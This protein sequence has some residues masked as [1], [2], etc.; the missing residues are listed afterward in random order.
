MF[1]RGDYYTVHARDAEFVARHVFQT[2]TVI[3][4]FGNKSTLKSGNGDEMDRAYVTLT[5]QV[6]ENLVRDLLMH[7]HY[8]V[9]IYSSSGSK[10]AGGWKLVRRGSPGN[11]KD[12]E[13]WLFDDSDMTSA[14]VVACVKVQNL[15][16]GLA[17]GDATHRRLGWVEF[18]DNALL[19][20]LESTIIQ[21]GV[22]ECLVHQFSSLETDMEKLVQLLQRCNIVVTE[23]KKSQFDDASLD[24]DLELLCCQKNAMTLTDASSARQTLACLMEYLDLTADTASHGQFELKQVAMKKYMRLDASAVQA[25]HMMPSGQD[26]SQ[27]HASL[28]GLLNHC[29]TA[30]GSRLLAT[31]LKQP[32]M[33]VAEIEKRQNLVQC[34]FDSAEL[35]QQFQEEHLKRV[36]DL[37]KLSKKFQ[38]SKAGIRDIVRFYDAVVQ[39]PLMTES[40][41]AFYD[42]FA[43]SEEAQVLKKEFLGP[44]EA[45][46]TQVEKFREMVEATV[47]LEATKNHLYRIRADYHENLVELRDEMDVLQQR[48]GNECERVASDL[49]LE[50]EKKLKLEKTSQFGYCMRIARA[51]SRFIAGNKTYVELSVQK[52]GIFFTTER[53]RGLSDQVTELMNSYE[54]KQADVVKEIVGITV[55]YAPVMEAMSEVFGMLDVIVAFAHV[56]INAPV[57]YARPKVHEKG[58]GDLVLRDARH[59]C[60]ELQDDVCFIAND[61]EMRRGTSQFNIITG[62]N[63]GG[64]STF[65]RQIGVIALLAQVGCF[66]PCSEAELP[67]FDAILAR[68]GAGDMQL[69]GVSTFMAEMLET[70]SILRTASPNS[71]VIVDE[72]GRGTSTYDGFGLAWAIS[73]DLAT[74]VGCFT[75]FATHFHELT[76]LSEQVSGV[77]NLHVE[78]VLGDEGIVLLYKVKPGAENQSFGIH[79]AEM[80][81]FPA[82]T[83]KMARRKVEELENLVM[84][85]R[86]AQKL[87]VST[88]GYAQEEVDNGL[89][90]V[91]V[92]LEA[93]DRLDADA[94]DDETLRSAFEPLISKFTDATQNNSFLK[95]EVIPLADR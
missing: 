65:I 23:V 43:H 73:H 9:E 1:D 42:T 19:S 52:S 8:R 94:M 91:S 46:A 35:R 75:L 62:P 10:A 11:L 63:M 53:M 70:A 60:L 27:R 22:K 39:L 56:A 81:K 34:F 12:F 21:L 51:D 2:T 26:G 79:C 58:Q 7:Q 13:D 3:K 4:Y 33:Q 29:S 84:N 89:G 86:D 50:L 80:A 5:Q 64:K 61:V 30:P 74:R 55:T 59:P 71:L 45:F 28:F 41:Q 20:D 93:I 67:V 90:A 54:E 32:L 36:P 95:Q 72:L 18:D 37:A 38:K 44:I 68:V 16:V 15:H 92:L 69:K 78:A 40:L 66:V 6:C 87:L 31:W 57:P 25:L 48:I 83:I 77:K 82:E 49:D 76:A 88:K 47:D 17:V 24:S 14:P 85:E